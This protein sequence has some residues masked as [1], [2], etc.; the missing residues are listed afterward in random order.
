MNIIFDLEVLRRNIIE[1]CD[2]NDVS[3]NHMLSE[4]VLAG[5]LWII[6][7]KAMSRSF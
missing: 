2:K 1:L 3:V 4:C 6:S 5:A 7:K